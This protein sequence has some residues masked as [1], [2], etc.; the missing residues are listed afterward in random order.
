MASDK[1]FL[2]Y[3]LDRL[4]G[5][6]DISYRPMMGEYLLYDRGRLFGGVY[7]NRLLLKQTVSVAA[8]LPDAPLAAPYPGA[9]EMLQ[10]EDLDDRALLEALVRAVAADLPP[11]KKR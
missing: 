3:V 2:D 9:K 6:G 11:A 4:S 7:D 8:L 1:R 10:V 5:I